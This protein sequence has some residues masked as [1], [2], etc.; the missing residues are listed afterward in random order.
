MELSFHKTFLSFR[1]KSIEAL[2]KIDQPAFRKVKAEMSRS[3]SLP[4]RSQVRRAHQS[5]KDRW[6]MHKWSLTCANSNF[7]VSIMTS[8][9]YVITQNSFIPGWGGNIVLARGSVAPRRWWGGRRIVWM[10][11]LWSC[12]VK[13]FFFFP[14]SVAPWEAYSERN[15]LLYCSLTWLRLFNVGGN[16]LWFLQILKTVFLYFA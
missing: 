11:R 2:L 14:F 8:L 7:Y 10:E 5:Q 16:M 15:F 9:C 1:E 3:D 13:F 12:L 6:M 4:T